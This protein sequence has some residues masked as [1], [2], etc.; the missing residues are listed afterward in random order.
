MELRHLRYFLAA[1]DGLHFGR[2]ARRMH[3]SQPTVSQQIRELEEE[4]GAALFER[5]G[6]GV[7]LT[8]AGELF[9]TYASRALEDVAAGSRALDA[10]AKREI[11]QLRVA[12]L[13]STTSGLVVP[14]LAAVLRKHPGVR[15]TAYEGRTR[16]VERLVL[17]GKVDVGIGLLPTRSHGLDAEPL[18]DG[19]LTL[20]V[21]ARHRLA[22]AASASL[23]DVADEPFALLSPT[24]RARKMADAELLRARITPRIVLEA[25]SVATVLAVVRAGLAISV[26]PAPR[27]TAAEHYSIA[28]AAAGARRRAAVPAWCPAH[29]PRRRVRHGGA[30]DRRRRGS[31]SNV[32]AAQNSSGPQ[33]S[34]WVPDAGG[35]PS[36]SFDFFAS[37]TK[38]RRVVRC[39]I[40]W[41]TGSRKS[42]STKL[43]PGASPRT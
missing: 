23:R 30:R 27:R 34:C 20:V 38:V 43:E 22:G 41:L 28:T 17:D 7:R 2:A 12:I 32:D 5:S 24:L 13:A 36:P 1:A 9:R 6:R 35:R 29:C 18:L 31:R 39:S 10:L 16:R 26:L 15:V 8:A 37:P 4:L 40:S 14:A 42:N 11:G 25:D 19:R 33:L 21:P 3:V